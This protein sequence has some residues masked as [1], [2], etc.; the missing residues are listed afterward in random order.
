MQ[1]NPRRFSP[2]L[3]WIVAGT[4]SSA[5]CLSA[6]DLEYFNVKDYGAT[7]DGVADDTAEIEATID[8]AA[9]A[10]RGTVFFPAGIYNTTGGHDLSGLH[11]LRILGSGIGSTVL[12]I[13][14]ATNDLFRST[15]ETH[16]LTIQDFSVTSPAGTRT[17]GWVY[18]AGSSSYTADG[19]LR[20]SRIESIDVKKQVN[21]FWIAQYEFV[22][23]KD[24]MMT[25]FVG[26]G[27][28]GIKAGQTTAS[29][30]NQGSELY[31]MGT[32]IYG[33]DFV[34]EDGVD[35]VALSTGLVI[36]DCDA[37][38]VLNSGIAGALMNSLKMIA[39]AGGHGPANHFFDQFV[40][41]G[42]RDSH[43]VYI[44]G[45]GTVAN[46]KFTGS[47]FASAGQMDGGSAG[48]NGIRIDVNN[49]G[50][51]EI[52]GSRIVNNK[53]TGLYIDL[54][55]SGGAPITI[56]GNTFSANGL[57]N[58]TNNKDGIFVNIALN[59][60]GPVITGNVLGASG[61]GIRTSSTSNRIVVVGNQLITGASFGITP[62]VQALN[63]G[64]GGNLTATAMVAGAGAPA[65]FTAGKGYSFSGVGDSD[66]GL[67][68]TADGTLGLYTNSAEA[69]QI[70]PSQKA[71][72]RSD[73][74][75]T[76]SF[77]APFKSFIEPHPHDPSK[78]IQYVSVEAPS[79]DVYFRGTA[80]L[81]SGRNRIEPPEHF[82]LV[83]SGPYTVLVTPVGEMAS[84]AVLEANASGIVL[85][86]SRAVMVNY[87]V[88]AER[89][90]F[91]GRSPIVENTHFIPQ[92]E[93]HWV[94][95]LPASYREILIRNG[96]L[97]SNGTTNLDTARRLGWAIE[98]AVPEKH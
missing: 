78:E 26:S 68:S 92:D 60:L 15:T 38:Y 34:G 63:D 96:T 49:L 98:K 80:R 67:F 9:L 74:Q 21:G 31:I 83:A 36:E 17:G 13:T 11:G 5:T 72:F 91:K 84:V 40:S 77:S 82:R 88:Y 42:T 69:L 8:A 43:G 28:I 81:E 3:L 24:L 47:W 71:I 79:A 50:Y 64:V 23:M 57:G 46:A 45:G 58:Q 87:V 73:L 61:L 10:G 55:N 75:V 4:L 85:Q 59:A 93:D 95:L 44:T 52:T 94:D 62:F 70:G 12:K 39:N 20:R 65:P 56:S 90:A 86:S 35:P 51:M 18:H 48:A 54:P 41:D 25:N 29:N 76:G 97:N 22:W 33:D 2:I 66:G 14:H 89:D 32:Q 16:D 27:G 7:G 6:E 37:V 19:H 30:K 53:G 1:W